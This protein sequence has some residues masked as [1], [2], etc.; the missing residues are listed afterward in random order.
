MID[1]YS[2]AREAADPDAALDEIFGMIEAAWAV[3][4]P[5]GEPDGRAAP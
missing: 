1:A 5:S 3:T 4:R 2:L